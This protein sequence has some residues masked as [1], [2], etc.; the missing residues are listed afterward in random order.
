MLPQSMMIAG[1]S[2][3]AQSLARSMPMAPDLR[4]GVLATPIAL[5]Q[6]CTAGIRHTTYRTACRDRGILS[7]FQRLKHL[8]RPTHTPKPG[9]LPLRSG[10]QI[11]GARKRIIIS[12]TA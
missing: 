2:F 1:L 10:L 7:P 3:Y 5:S 11:D 8:A 6:C 12:P 4:S 9:E